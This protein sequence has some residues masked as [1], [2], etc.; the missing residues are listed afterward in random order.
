MRLYLVLIVA[1]CL[2]LAACGARDEP[3][4]LLDDEAH[5]GPSLEPVDVRVTQQAGTC[6]IYIGSE[7]WDSEV[8]CISAEAARLPHGE[9]YVLIGV[10]EK[11]C[12]EVW[13]IAAQRQEALFS[14]LLENA[15]IS[16]SAVLYGDYMLL[17]LPRELVE[18][19]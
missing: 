6:R 3:V 19:L 4:V 9:Q 12:E 5:I 14:D 2:L 8:H 1:F 11:R 18:A 7:S 13:L 17:K 10:Q 15:P 16:E